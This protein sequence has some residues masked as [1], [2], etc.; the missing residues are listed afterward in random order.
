MIR[1]AF[2]RSFLSMFY[3]WDTKGRD[4]AGIHSIPDNAL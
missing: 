4:I 3:P 2:F 1:P